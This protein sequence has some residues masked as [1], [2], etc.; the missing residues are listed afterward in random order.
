MTQAWA[1]LH[2]LAAASPSGTP[3][4]QTCAQVLQGNA[5]VSCCAVVRNCQRCIFVVGQPSTFEGD[6]LRRL[7]AEA[8]VNPGAKGLLLQ[9]VHV[10]GPA[11]AVSCA[12][13]PFTPCLI[14]T[15]STCSH[16][17]IARQHSMTARL[18][19]KGP[20]AD[21]ALEQPASP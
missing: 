1:S 12:S 4:G 11:P 8:A 17:C 5:H 20:P 15:L 14:C 6:E 7:E 19:T 10:S 21:S 16:D 2:A 9:H 18:D 13:G 3:K